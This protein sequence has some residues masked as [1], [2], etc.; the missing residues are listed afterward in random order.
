MEIFLSLAVLYSVLI[1]FFFLGLHSPKAQKNTTINKI[2]IIVAARNEAENLPKLLNRL[3]SQNYPTEKY[4][5]IICDD[6]SDDNSTA[7]IKEFQ[8]E[9][10][11]LQLIQIKE[12]DPKILGKKGAITTAVK[13][14]KY[15]ILAFTDADCQPSVN[16][17]QEINK[18]FP[19][20]VDFVAGYSTIQHENKFFGLMK[21]LERSAI[22][23]VIAGAFGFNWGITATAGNMA[24]RKKLFD[25]VNGF[26]GIGHIRSG[27][28]DLMLHKMW[29]FIRNLRFMF[30][31]D[32]IVVT[33]GCAD[34]QQQINQETR[35]GSKWKIYP[36]SIKLVTLLVMLF[37][38]SYILLLLFT[39][40]GS[41]TWC[42]FGIVTFLKIV[43]EFLLTFSFL[44]KV[45]N[46]KYLQVFPIA[47][48][49]YIPYF[50]FFGLKGTFGK[51]RWKE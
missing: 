22:F 11:N 39:I 30:S 40:L 51:Y 32:S 48:I 13:A 45:K 8:S 9:N 6:R 49:I 50:I 2:S 33:Q 20:D 41:Y 19:E 14:S 4:E 7:I 21:N 28:D 1:L 18:H 16:W 24:Y 5:I 36:F 25:E 23:A 29:K 44:L 17:L 15:D 34:V 42:F 27:D 37:Y 31:T 10:P 3:T 46:L 43:P 12:E 38:I 47:E 35:R 26:E